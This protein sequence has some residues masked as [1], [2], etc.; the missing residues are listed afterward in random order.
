M[1][2]T[3]QPSPPAELQ[4]RAHL[5]TKLNF[6]E[7]NCIH[8]CEVW[9]ASNNYTERNWMYIRELEFIRLR[10]CYFVLQNMLSAYGNRGLASR[11]SDL[12]KVRFGVTSSKS[13]K[14]EHEKR[15]NIILMFLKIPQATPDFQ[16]SVRIQESV[17]AWC[18]GDLQPQTAG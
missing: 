9:T 17:H 8:V 6:E 18:R 11:R 7:S 13:L 1:S 2:H 4:P 5:L 10:L 15:G 12:A 16:I 14:Q 3:H